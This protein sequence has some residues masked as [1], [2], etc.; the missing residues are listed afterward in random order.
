MA[1]KNLTLDWWRWEPAPTPRPR[2]IPITRMVL[3]RNPNFRGETYPRE[4]EPG[5]GP[6]GLLEDC[7]QPLPFVDAAVFT[8]EKGRFPIGTSFFRGY[9]DASGISS[10]S[11]NQAVRVTVGGDVA[12]DRRDAG[13]G[14]SGS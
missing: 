3:A 8:R 1:A 13:H 14:A 4:G 10:D 7:G 2:T 9:Y 12:L 6:A 5:D 11:F